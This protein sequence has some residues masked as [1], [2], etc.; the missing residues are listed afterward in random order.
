MTRNSHVPAGGPKSKN[1]THPKV[2]TGS[3]SHST[4]PG[5]VAA[6]GSS[7]GDHTDRNPSTGYRGPKFHD[8]KNFQPTPFGNEIAARTVCGPGGSRKVYGSGTQQTY[9]AANPGNPPP[10]SRRDALNND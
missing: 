6:L 8:G 9:G 3:G 5:G 4:R 7:Y 10:N 2:R 1:V